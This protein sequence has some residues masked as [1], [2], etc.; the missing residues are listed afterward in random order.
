[1]YVMQ[2][3]TLPRYTP[4][5]SGCATCGTGAVRQ[6]SLTGLSAVDV[7]QSPAAAAL[8]LARG[9]SG[10]GQDEDL[11]IGGGGAAAV[12]AVGIA[13]VVSLLAAAGFLSYKAGKAM[14]P[15]GSKASTWGWVGVPV[16]MF[17]GVWGLGVMGW[18][19][20]SK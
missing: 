17:T 8:R 5:L 19:A 16:G 6:A 11:M 1:M 15:S 4:A 13:V 3:S 9:A 20:G 18:V 2:Q 7:L 10:L 12:G 14:A